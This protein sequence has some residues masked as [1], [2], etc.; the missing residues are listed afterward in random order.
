LTLLK[1]LHVV[2]AILWL[3][4]FAVTGV[5]ALRALLRRRPALAAFAAGEI[6]FTDLLFTL[7]FG[8]AVVV[9]GIVLAQAEG[10]AALATA[11]TRLALVVVVAS[12]AVWLLALLPIELTMYRRSLEN[13]SFG[14]LFLLWNVIGWLLT[15]ALFCVVYLMVAKPV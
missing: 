13:A 7:G 5:W 4:N 2:A 10:I 9:S 8:S 6:L 1:T 3:G 15:V 12:G 11:W 14:K